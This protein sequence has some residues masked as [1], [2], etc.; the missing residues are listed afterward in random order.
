M[1]F[2]HGF[3]ATAMV[4]V[5]GIA[6]AQYDFNDFNEAVDKGKVNAAATQSQAS[7]SSADPNVMRQFASSGVTLSGLAN[8][9]TSP[10]STTVSHE[11]TSP[12]AMSASSSRMGPYTTCGQTASFRARAVETQ[13]LTSCGFLKGHSCDSDQGCK[14]CQPLMTHQ[15]VNLPPPASL[16]GYFNASPCTANVWDGYACEAAAECAK[17]QRKLAPPSHH[18]GWTDSRKARCE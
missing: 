2:I 9:G 10:A 4:F 7:R 15:P 5:S 1:R 8:S 14:I 12:E 13:P 17:V 3:A 18:D 16:R 6:S 11:T